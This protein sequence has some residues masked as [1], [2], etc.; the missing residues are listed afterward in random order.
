MTCINDVQNDK[1]SPCTWSR[2]SMALS[3]P[4]QSMGAWLLCTHYCTASRPPN[5]SQKH[6]AG[7]IRNCKT[8][9]GSCVGIIVESRRRLVSTWAF[10]YSIMSSKFYKLSSSTSPESPLPV[11]A[12]TTTSRTSP[13]DSC[14][15]I[16]NISHWYRLTTDITACQQ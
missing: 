8:Q 2:P 14:T 6:I 3:I 12:R 9:L 4:D 5:S 13:Y 15:L 1:I 16:M 11:A 7:F 10:L